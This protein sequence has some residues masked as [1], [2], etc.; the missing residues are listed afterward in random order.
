MKTLPK[1]LTVGRIA[2]RLK[3]PVHRVQYI[4][5]TRLYIAPAALAGRTR[6]FNTKAVAQIR[7]ETN[8]IDARRQS[9]GDV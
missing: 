6:L 9:G 8:A 4:L 7:H 5:A 1:L 2:E 3:I